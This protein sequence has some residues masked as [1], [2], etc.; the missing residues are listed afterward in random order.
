MK[1]SY[2]LPEY[3]KDHLAGE[4]YSFYP[5]Q[6]ED[7]S[8]PFP[9][10]TDYSDGKKIVRPQLDD[11]AR[12]AEIL[13]QMAAILDNTADFDR[14]YERMRKAFDD[15]TAYQ[16]GTFSLFSPAKPAEKETVALA[17]IAP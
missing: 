6:P 17:P 16:N 5:Y 12:V 15:L 13:I 10:G 14:N 8:R 7:L 11:P 1:P 3:E 2:H 9:Y 4:V